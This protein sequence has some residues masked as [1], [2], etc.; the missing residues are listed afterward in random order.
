MCVLLIAWKLREGLPLVV[1]ANRDESRQRASSPPSAVRLGQRRV[2]M[3]R[4]QVAGGT[5][6]GVNDAGV[7]VAITNRADG[8]FDDERASRGQLPF[9]ALELRSALAV[10]RMLEKRTSEA[11]FNSFNLFCADNE[12][13]W[14]AS[15]NGVLQVTSLE[16]GAYVLTNSHDLDELAVPEFEALSRAASAGTVLRDSLQ[17][18]LGN[19]DGR[20]A[21]G[22]PLC[23][24]GEQYGA[25]SATVFTSD[26]RGGWQ[27][28][29]SAGNPCR[30]PFLQYYLD[31]E[32][33][34]PE[35]EPDSE[36]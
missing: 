13:A 22:Y 24:H 34:R 17:E 2:L 35:P 20:D 7:A 5:W 33:N 1:A 3:P 9:A 15:W 28:R 25:V 4:D 6:L 21:D 11:H 30:T 31:G 36:V 19:H 10:R 16:P 18:L 32:T 23:K 12:H 26:G 8:S 29:F 14:V 27:M